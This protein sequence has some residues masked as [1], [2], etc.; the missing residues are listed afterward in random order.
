MG[1]YANAMIE[2]AV[3]KKR[4][5]LETCEEN[6]LQSRK[7][8]E[9]KYE[10]AY[11][12]YQQLQQVIDEKYQV[13]SQVLYQMGG[14]VTEWHYQLSRLMSDFSQQTDSVYKDRQYQLEQE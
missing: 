13:A 12:K 2:D 11:S 7:K 3:L 10:E 14:D 4:R 5:Q 9:K 6:F 1:G 8:I